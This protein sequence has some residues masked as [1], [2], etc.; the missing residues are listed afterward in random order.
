MSAV[1]SGCREGAMRVRCSGAGAPCCAVPCYCSA[2]A[3][4]VQC[5]A[6]MPIMGGVFW[7]LI[8]NR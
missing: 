2:N 8:E 5:N 6:P 3:Y 4:A 7:Q 1:N